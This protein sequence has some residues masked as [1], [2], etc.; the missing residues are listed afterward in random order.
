MMYVRKAIPKLRGTYTPGIWADL[1]FLIVFGFLIPVPL[2]VALIYSPYI[3]PPTNAD[4]WTAIL[5][6]FLSI[7]FT[8]VI[9]TATGFRYSWE[10]DGE[11][12]IR[13]GRCGKIRQRLLIS[14]I[15]RANFT[16]KDRHGNVALIIETRDQRAVILINKALKEELYY[17]GIHMLV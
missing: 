17:A 15:V 6:P 13:R 3:Y 4:E 1:F 7:L 14:E 5:M 12:I 16:A 2:I 11:Q 9:L 8:A 10:F